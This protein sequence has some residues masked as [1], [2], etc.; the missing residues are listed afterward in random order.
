MKYLKLMKLSKGTADVITDVI[1]VLSRLFSGV[2]HHLLCKY[3]P[4]SVH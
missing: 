1:R 4:L 2:L 3:A